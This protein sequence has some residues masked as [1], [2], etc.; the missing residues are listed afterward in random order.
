[1]PETFRQSLSTSI[2]NVV[3]HKTVCKQEYLLIIAYDPDVMW[4]VNQNLHIHVPIVI[5]TYG[6]IT[7]F[8]DFLINKKT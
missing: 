6:K 5:H 8:R 2:T 4:L 7:N 1:M 3:V